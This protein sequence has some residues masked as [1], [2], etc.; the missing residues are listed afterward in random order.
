MEPSIKKIIVGETIKLSHIDV[1]ENKAIIHFESGEQLVVLDEIA[2]WFLK[3]EAGREAFSL[4][5]N[6]SN[7][8]IAYSL[9]WVVVT[10]ECNYHT[11]IKTVCLQRYGSPESLEGE[12]LWVRGFDPY[13]EFVKVVYKSIHNKALNVWQD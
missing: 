2:V 13:S 1:Y 10:I 11:P 12:P 3:T 7:T 4:N 8:P 9:H 5:F 6:E